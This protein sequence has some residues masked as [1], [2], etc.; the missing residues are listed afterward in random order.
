MK[1]NKQ[2]LVMT[3]SR[4]QSKILGLDNY[5]CRLKEQQTS[6]AWSLY[7]EKHCSTQET[8]V[9]PS[10]ACL[11]YLEL[12]AILVQSDFMQETCNPLQPSVKE[13]KNAN[14]KAE[15]VEV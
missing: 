10:F 15:C 11:C 6:T 7:R 4:Q 8:P 3:L 9:F 5:N 12:S 1:K 2:Y 13:W 14:S